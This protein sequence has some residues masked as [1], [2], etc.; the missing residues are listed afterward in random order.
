MVIAPSKRMSSFNYGESSDVSKLPASAGVGMERLP[1]LAGVGK[2]RLLASAGVG[3][4]RLLASA[5]VGEIW[6]QWYQ[7]IQDLAISELLQH[8][9]FSMSAASDPMVTLKLSMMQQMDD[10]YHLHKEMRKQM[11]EGRLIQGYMEKKA[12]RKQCKADERV[13]ECL[14]VEKRRD[15]QH[16][17]E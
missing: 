1:A 6:N 10:E 14:W 2:E 4:E 13:M 15:H 11:E 5:G 3:E 9:K 12:K 17:T 7:E 16:Y 8:L